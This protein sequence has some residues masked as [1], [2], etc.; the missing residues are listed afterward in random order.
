MLFRAGANVIS[1]KRTVHVSSHGS[2]EELKFMI[3]LM[4]PKF[5]SCSW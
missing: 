3:N 5:Y 4:K 1:G 2:Q